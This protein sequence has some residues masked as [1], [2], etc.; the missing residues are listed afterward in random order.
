MKNPEHVPL[1]TPKIPPL[2]LPEAVP[3]EPNSDEQ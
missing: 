3:H 1:G 2:P